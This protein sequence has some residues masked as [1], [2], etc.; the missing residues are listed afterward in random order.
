MPTF[1]L[2]DVDELQLIGVAIVFGRGLL[3]NVPQCVLMGLFLYLGFSA[4][5]GNT[6]LERI[7]LFFTD[8]NKLPDVPYVKDISLSATKKFTLLQV[9]CLAAL[10]ALKES[11]FGILFPVVIA[12]LQVILVLAVKAGWFTKKELEVLDD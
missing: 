1:F 12:L 11:R 8:K 7:E 5:K 6:F 10:V 2:S 3:R 4:I 9:G